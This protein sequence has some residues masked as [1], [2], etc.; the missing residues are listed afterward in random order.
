MC[1]T[2]LSTIILPPNEIAV[3]FVPVF[4]GNYKTQLRLTDGKNHSASFEGKIFYTQFQPIQDEQ[5]NYNKVYLEDKK[6]RKGGG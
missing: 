6:K 3:T 1:G 2:G 5:G 4:K